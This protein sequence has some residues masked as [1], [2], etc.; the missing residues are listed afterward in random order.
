MGEPQRA[1][2]AIIAHRLKRE[3][4]VV[5]AM[6]AHPD[7]TPEALLAAV[8]DDVPERLH[9]MAMRSLTAHLHKLRSDG[10]ARELE[11][12]WVLVERSGH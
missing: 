3:A 11:R 9:P 6:R 8:Y 7:A 2:E 5:G 12:R 4:K 1:I 10:A